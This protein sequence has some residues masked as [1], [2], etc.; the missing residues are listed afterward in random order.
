M[1]Y[2]LDNHAN[3][4]NNPMK[5]IQESLELFTICGPQIGDDYTNYTEHGVV[6]AAKVFSGIKLKA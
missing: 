3:N 5:I 4:K 1:L 2:Y 6:M